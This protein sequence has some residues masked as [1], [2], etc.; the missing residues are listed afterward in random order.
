MSLTK[1][2]ICQAARDHD[3][4]DDDDGDAADDDDVVAKEL[5]VQI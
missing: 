1:P 3:D 2:E 5:P 4:Y